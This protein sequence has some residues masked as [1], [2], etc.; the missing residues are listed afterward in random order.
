M[1]LGDVSIHQSMISPSLAL[2]RDV[3]VADFLVTEEV[4]VEKKNIRYGF[5]IADLGLLVDESTVAEVVPRP[6]PVRIPRTPA[7]FS[8]LSNLRGSL[9]PVFD[10]K[11]L[12][13]LPDK[14]SG[15]EKYALVVGRGDAA[16][17]FFIEQYPKGFDDL[18]AI[19]EPPPLP[20]MFQAFSG[21]AYYAQDS[22]YVEFNY[23]RFFSWLSERLAT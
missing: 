21:Q 16:M 5:K 3:H 22:V 12:L 1:S 9:V 14:S 20:K 10:L 19:A 15:L 2:R 6:S 4:V 23:S 18:D 7:W 17:G 8:G 13:G 11:I